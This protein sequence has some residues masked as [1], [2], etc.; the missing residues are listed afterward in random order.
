MLQT[1]KKL[2]TYFSKSTHL[3][4]CVQRRLVTEQAVISHF[5]DM[6]QLSGLL[7]DFGSEEEGSRCDGVAVKTG[8]RMIHVEAVHVNNGCVDSQLVTEL[9]VKEKSQGKGETHLKITIIYYC[10]CKLKKRKKEKVLYSRG[11]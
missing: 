3:R 10:G 8:E 9:L 4:L 1:W 6:F 5:D 11:I 7:L 2:Q